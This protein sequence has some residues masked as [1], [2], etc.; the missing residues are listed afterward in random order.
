MPKPDNSELLALRTECES[1]RQ[2]IATLNNQ[3]RSLVQSIEE[4]HS[5]LRTALEG[6]TEL[7]LQLSKLQ[8]RLDELLIQL[9]RNNDR[10]YGPTTERHNPRPSTAV[11]AATSTSTDNNAASADIPSTKPKQKRPRNHKKH[12]LGQNVPDKDVIHL[13]KPEQRICP[14]C[15]VETKFVSYTVTNQLERLLQSLVRLNHKE[16]IR[17]CPKCKGYVVSGKKPRPPIPGGLAGPCL[18]SDVVVSKFA[19]ALPNYRQE[20]IFQR[21]D[22]TIPRQT[23]CDW[24][25]AASLVLEPLYEIIKREIL[26]SKVI[27]TDDTGVKIQNRKRKSKMRRG[28][29][30]AYRGDRNHPYVV[31]D[32]SPDESFEQNLEFLRSYTGNVQA[33]AATGFDALFDDGTGKTEI[34]CN[35][36]SRRKYFECRLTYAV[37]CNEILDIYHQLYKVEKQIRDKDSATRKLARQDKSKPLTESLHKKLLD[38]KNTLNP[39][40]PLMKAVNYSLNHWEALVRFLDDPDFDIDNN[41]CERAIKGWVLVRKNALF[42]GSDRGGK[43]AAIHL[44]FI[45]SCKR[46]K[47]NPHEYLT[48][49]FTRIGGM[50]AEELEQLLPDRW[51][52][53]RSE[54]E[55]E[56]PFPNKA[57]PET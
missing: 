22:A 48:D 46:N 21:E 18:L 28:K 33:D 35:A 51:S 6:N 10:D 15:D 3:I 56:K 20:S 45:A 40:N 31:F 57:P 12:I 44:S 27:Q 5:Q 17:S 13:V 37:V 8:D 19:D 23:Q 55:K 30:T 38:L 11:D 52:K 29:M 16:E 26:S 4:L 32:F 42:V 53:P 1:Q 47:I 41:A 25:I 54:P 50:Q 9:R 39:T 7:K 24:V 49:V 34:G 2:T 36:H 14:H 43:A